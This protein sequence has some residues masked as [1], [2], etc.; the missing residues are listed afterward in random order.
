L[1]EELNMGTKKV[2]EEFGDF[3]IGRKVIHSVI[4]G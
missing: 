3:Q 4:C 1:K 2:L